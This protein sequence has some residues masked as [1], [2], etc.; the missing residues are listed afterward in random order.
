[1]FD[2]DGFSNVLIRLDCSELPLAGIISC[3]ARPSFKTHKEDSDGEEENGEQVLHRVSRFSAYVF[4]IQALS[5]VK[6]I[7]MLNLCS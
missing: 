6:V 7:A 3:F 5:L 2:S 4:D 1:M